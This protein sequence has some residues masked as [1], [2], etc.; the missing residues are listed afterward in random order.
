MDNLRLKGR[1]PKTVAVRVLGHASCAKVYG[2]PSKVVE[3][4]VLM[5]QT[6]VAVYARGATLVGDCSGAHSARLVTL[7]DNAAAVQ[8]N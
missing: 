8:L 5:A 3:A 4:V 6:R 1:L 7:L 2:N